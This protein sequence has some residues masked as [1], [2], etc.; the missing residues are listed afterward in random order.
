[1]VIRS[2][3]LPLAWAFLALMLIVPREPANGHD[4]LNNRATVGDGM[5]STVERSRGMFPASASDPPRLAPAFNPGDGRYNYAPSVIQDTRHRALYAFYCANRVPG[6]ITD[7]I[8]SRRA[9]RVNG[10]WVWGEERVSLSPSVDRSMW[11][12]RHVCDPDVVAGRF[13]FAGQSWS[14][15]LFYL[16]CDAEASTHNQVG[17]AFAHSL[18]GPW[19]KYPSPIVHYSTAPDSG[20]VRS[21]NGWPVWRYWGVGQPSVVS[22]DGL[23]KLLL[24]YSRGDEE[25]GEE[26]VDVD[27]AN[28]DTGPQIGPR[29]KVPTEGLTRGNGQPTSY[30]TNIGV[31]YEPRHDRYFM[32]REGD[33][34]P[35]DGRFPGFVS[36][37]VQ[38]AWIEG[39]DL[40]AGRGTWQALANLGP[41]ST[42]W[43]R[44]HNASLLKDARG[45]I[46]SS[47]SL[48][49]CFSVAE[50]YNSP[51]PSNWLWTYRVALVRLNLAGGPA[52]H[53]YITP[54]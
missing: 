11:D 32:V 9:I 23:G 30:L 26:M 54:S 40:R 41:E 51:P 21:T 19:F 16:G 24:F 12:S 48:T 18:A 35:E 5:N 4:T 52:S 13:H 1:M 38:V 42:G 6:Q 45:R 22:L 43:P 53:N 29:R 7:S 50:A 37:F 3:A 46:P 20:V 36:A 28:M 49:I 2:F 31:A 25:G 14:F 33:L 39:K 47:N 17:V 10:A 34:P 8:C 27:L 44:N 15:A